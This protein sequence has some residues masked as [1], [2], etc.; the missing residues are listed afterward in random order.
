[1]RPPSQ[2][3]AALAPSMNPAAS[4]FA[5]PSHDRPMSGKKTNGSAPRPV[6]SAVTLAARNTVQTSTAA[7]SRQT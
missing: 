2:K 4:E 7:V 3:S 5:K 6:A 1:M